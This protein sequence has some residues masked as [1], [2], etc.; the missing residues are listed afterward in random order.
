MGLYE[1]PWEYPAKTLARELSYHVVY[2]V[3]T[4]VAYDVVD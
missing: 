1:P 2:G 3:G 4:A